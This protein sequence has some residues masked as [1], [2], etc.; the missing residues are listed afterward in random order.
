MPRAIVP[1]LL[2]VVL[3]IGLLVLLS[4]QAK[5]VPTRTIETDVSLPAN[6]R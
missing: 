3:L 4:S 1:I 2:V 5:E 6:A